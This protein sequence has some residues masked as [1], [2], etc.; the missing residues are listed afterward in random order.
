MPNSSRTDIESTLRDAER[1]IQDET[2][3]E[4]S[5]AETAAIGRVVMKPPKVNAAARAAEEFSTDIE[6]RS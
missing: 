3:W 1:V 2:R 6:I 4:L 5:E